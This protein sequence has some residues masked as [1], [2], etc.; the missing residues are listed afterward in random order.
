[1]KGPFKEQIYDHFSKSP[2]GLNF[3]FQFMMGVFGS[4]ATLQFNV[5]SDIESLKVPYKIIEPREQSMNEAIDSV[6]EQVYE[7]FPLRIELYEPAY[8]RAQLGKQFMRTF[9]EANPE[10]IKDP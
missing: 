4:E 8:Q 7:Q 5:I 1:M 2:E 6:L 9:F 3:D 10:L